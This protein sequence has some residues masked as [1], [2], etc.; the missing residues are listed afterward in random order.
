MKAKIPTVT[1]D[2]DTKNDDD[3]D[4]TS[5]D[6]DDKAPPQTDDDAAPSDDTVPS[7]YWKCLTDNKT[8][9]EC[10]TD[11]CAWCVSYDIL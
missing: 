10:T 2:D 5:A 3:D 1:C 7:D 4:S 8:S 9:G 6:D 11:G